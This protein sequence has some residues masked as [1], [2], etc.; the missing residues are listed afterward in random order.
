MVRTDVSY[1]IKLIVGTDISN[2]IPTTNTDPE[3]YI[4]NEDNLT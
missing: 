3:S 4:A 2:S 1:S